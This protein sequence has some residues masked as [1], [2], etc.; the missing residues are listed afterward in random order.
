MNDTKRSV[1]GLLPGGPARVHASCLNS[2]AVQYLA[3]PLQVTSHEGDY[4][5]VNLSL[6]LLLFAPTTGWMHGRGTGEETAVAAQ[7]DTGIFT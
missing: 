5:Q 2:A 1:N 6:Q 4:L 3:G 7:N